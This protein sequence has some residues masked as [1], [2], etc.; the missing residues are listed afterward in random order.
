MQEMTKT[1]CGRTNV[2]VIDPRAVFTIDQ[3]RS[4]LVLAKNCLP[5]EKRLGRLRVAK[6]AGKYLIMGQWLLEWIAAGELPR[7]NS[8]S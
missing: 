1:K 2:P 4:T 3:A 7:G 5:R 6:R 8:Q